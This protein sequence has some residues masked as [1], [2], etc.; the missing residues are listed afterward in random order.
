[1]SSFTTSLCRAEVIAMAR[2]RCRA[3][4]RRQ[5]QGQPFRD[6]GRDRR[7]ARARSPAQG[8][9]VA[10][11]KAGDPLVFG[12]AGEEMKALRE[13]GI[14]FEIVPGITAALAAAADAQDAADAARRRFLPRLRDRARRRRVRARGLGRAGAQRAARSPSTWAR[15]PGAQIRDRLA[16]AGLPAATPVVAVENA[17]RA[18]RRIFSGQLADLPA[19]QRCA[20]T[21]R[22]PCSSSPARPWPQ[23]DLDERRRHRPHARRRGVTAPD[24]RPPGHDEEAPLRHRT[25][26]DRQRHAATAASCSARPMA[27]GRS[28]SPPPIS[29]TRRRRPRRCCSPPP[30][31]TPRA[32]S[33]STPTS[34]R[35]RAM[36][37]R[38]RPTRLRELDPRRPAPRSARPPTRSATPPE[39]PSTAHVSLRRIRPAL[40]PGARRRVPRPGGA[41]PLR[42][43]DRGPV[44]AAA[45]DERRLSAAARLHA[46]HRHSLRHAV[47]APDA[48]ARLHRAHLRPQ[49]R[50]LHDAPEPPVQL[51]RAEGRAGDPRS[52]SPRSRCT[53][54][55]TSGNC[56]RNVTADHFAGAAADEVADP[57]PYAEILRQWS[58]L[59]PEFTYLPRKF[60]I[61][62]TGAP[63]DRA[64]IQVH[65]IGLEVKRNEAG[66]TRLRGL[67][68]RRPG[69]HADDRQEDPRLPARERAA[70]LLHGDPARLQPLRPPRQQVQGAHQDPRP[71]DRASRRSRATSR[72]SSRPSR[73]T[74]V[75]LD[76]AEA[77]R[78]TAS[79]PISRRPPSTTLPARVRSVRDGATAST[80]SFAALRRA[81]RRGA[82]AAGLC[83]VTVS[84]KPIGGAPGDATAEQ[85]DASPTSPSATRSTSSASATS[86]T[87][88]CRM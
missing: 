39:P 49:L 67:G 76:A 19:L 71:R 38:L 24:R 86:R 44:Q 84:L 43:A 28:D 20:S 45:A 75:P 42:R 16:D 11:L 5:G 59:H 85:M 3:H 81:Q 29:P 51:D 18:H 88:C 55:Q 15:A 48:Q 63:N 7:A 6:A 62:V 30:S 57:R 26:R 69:P 68:R 40:R 4:Q 82:P 37:G 2:P 66:E 73:P 27:P 70:R 78:S 64:A 72:P 54:I 17:G 32:P 36:S 35:S 25:R 58:S 34:S 22:D 50:P 12:R 9:R 13:A 60:K 79:P 10:R 31:A 14:P 80:P 21:S 56:I 23:A 74:D 77:R 53:A 87:S 83:R 1:M 8:K 65:D 46:A 61:A 52:I 47:V 33:S 41:P